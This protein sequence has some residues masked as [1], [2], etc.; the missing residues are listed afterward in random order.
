M[1]IKLRR[2]LRR[3]LTTVGCLWGG[4]EMVLHWSSLVCD[5]DFIKAVLSAVTAAQSALDAEESLCIRG[6]PQAA[7]MSVKADILDTEAIRMQLPWPVV[8]RSKGLSELSQSNTY[9][10]IGSCYIQSKI[11]HYAEWGQQIAI[12]RLTESTMLRA[13][14]MGI[15]RFRNSFCE[16][17][18]VP[19]KWPYN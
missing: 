11:T 16:S 1:S 6:S 14:G 15:K 8:A 3:T 17:A 4:S 9:N 19:A 18:F 7:K 10:I 13:S 5:L 12:A 2:Q